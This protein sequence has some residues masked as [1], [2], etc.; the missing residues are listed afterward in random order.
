MARLHLVLISLLC[1]SLFSTS[2]ANGPMS[3][4]QNKKPSFATG[5]GKKKPRKNPYL[6]KSYAQVIQ[7]K[8]KALKNNDLKTALTCLDALR[9]NSENETQSQEVLL[10]M[11]HLY[12]K[13]ENWEKAEHA[14]HE[15]VLFNPSAP[16]IEFA[17]CKEIECGWKLT[18]NSDRDQTKTQEVLKLTQNFIKQFP[19]SEQL[20]EVQKYATL[21]REK[22]YESDKGIFNFHMHRGNYKVAQK[23]LDII[24]KQ[25]IP[26]LPA[27]AP[28]AYELTIQLAQA[29]NNTESLLRAQLDLGQKFPDHEITKRLV[30]DLPTVKT[31]LASLEKDKLMAIELPQVEAIQLAQLVDGGSDTLI[32]S[33]NQATAKEINQQ[34]NMLN[35]PK[36]KDGKKIPQ[37]STPAI[38]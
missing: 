36:N 1:L 16:K 22:L 12:Q 6:D 5:E 27:Y 9:I 2:F 4:G 17:M 26:D 34:M 10:E 33:Q 35:A 38:T 3:F 25:D 13:Q 28:Q 14:Y 18:S 7:D 19:K 31:Q 11:G 37:P 23:R 29:Q 8:E 21:C 20:K 32:Q 15:F 30:T 24:T